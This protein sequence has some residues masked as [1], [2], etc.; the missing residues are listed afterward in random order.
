[1]DRLSLLLF[2]IR[3]FNDIFSMS[4]VYYVQKVS[5]QIVCTGY[6]CDP[7]LRGFGRPALDSIDSGPAEIASCWYGR[8][9][10]GRVT[11]HLLTPLR[12]P[13][14]GYCVG[15]EFGRDNE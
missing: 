1:M 2:I 6:Y 13:S 15:L 7:S 12:I 4:G 8:V 3:L 10:G 9:L 11:H 5:F 14:G